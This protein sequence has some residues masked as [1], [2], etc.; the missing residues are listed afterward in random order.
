VP[1]GDNAVITAHDEENDV[2]TVLN[3]RLYC[4]AAEVDLGVL[5]KPFG[6]KFILEQRKPQYIEYDPIKN[7]WRSEGKV[8]PNEK[9]RTILGK[10]M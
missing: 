1:C 4:E 10:Y 5:V 8:I 2:D 3:R 6:G 7:E 9:I